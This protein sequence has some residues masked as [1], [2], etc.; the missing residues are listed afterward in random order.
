MPPPLLHLD[1]VAEERIQEAIR[2]G[3]FDNLPGVGRPLALDEDPLVPAELRIA[4]RILSNAG[5]V[6]VEVLERREIADLKAS[7]AS[8][9]DDK[10]RR[11]VLVRL[12]LLR[13]RLG[14]RRTVC[15]SRNAS[16]ARRVTEKLAGG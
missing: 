7:L 5:L 13:L 4:N 10:A 2:R 15:L 3:E 1:A 9:R 11:R 16:Y 12:A 6:P 8:L 14:P